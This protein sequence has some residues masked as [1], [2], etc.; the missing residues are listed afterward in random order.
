M[1]ESASLNDILQLAGVAVALLFCVI[2]IVRRVSSRRHSE[3]CDGSCSQ[4]PLSDK[5]HGKGG[6]CGCH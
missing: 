5:C 3:N 6:S 1:N 4:C 2:Y